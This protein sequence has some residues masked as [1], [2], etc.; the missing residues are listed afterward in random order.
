[1]NQG[2]ITIRP[3]AWTGP[4]VAT[5]QPAVWNIGIGLTQ[6]SS[7]VNPRRPMESRA[8]LVIARWASRAPFGN[9]VVPD[10]YWIW[11]GSSGVTAG[12]VPPAPAW[13][14]PEARKSSKAERS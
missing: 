10:V 12:S 5:T 6:A 9:P 4:R 8:L 3:R 14:S 1:S 11:A 2:A 7:D 13:A